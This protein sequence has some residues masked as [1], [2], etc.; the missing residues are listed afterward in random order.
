MT[1]YVI[2]QQG[3]T[4]DTTTTTTTYWMWTRAQKQLIFQKVNQVVSIRRI[5]TKILDRKV[6]KKKKK[7]WYQYYVS[8]LLASK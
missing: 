6:K 8:V 5:S 2:F 7:D 3:A 1:M 4:N